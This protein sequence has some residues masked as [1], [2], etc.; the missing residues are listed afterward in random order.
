M[1]KRFFTVEEAN[2]LLPRIDA[3]VEQ[4]QQ[5]KR[6][7][8]AKYQEL[9]K[10]RTRIGGGGTLDE[11][12]FFMVEAQ[13]EFLNIQARG[14]IDRINETGAQLKD[15]EMG[16]VDFPAKKGEEEVLLCW[17]KGEDRVSH[18][19]HLWEGYMYRKT[20]DENGEY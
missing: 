2:R 16:L 5:L 19:H 10:L 12:P 17:R 15:I 14:I 18:W 3:D 9:Q 6:E 13:L 8:E 20:L 11:D 1:A 7:F 4:L